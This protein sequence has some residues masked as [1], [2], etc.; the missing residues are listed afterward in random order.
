MGKLEEICVRKLANIVVP[1][2]RSN[3]EV[4]LMCGSEH[5]DGSLTADAVSLRPNDVQVDHDLFRWIEQHQIGGCVQQ[6]NRGDCC[7][8][9]RKLLSHLPIVTRGG[10]ESKQTCVLGSDTFEIRASFGRA[11]LYI[12][13]YNS[14]S[15]PARCASP[16]RWLR[17]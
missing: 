4:D 5:G 7:Q 10:G 12:A 15:V 1:V 14:A 16:R 8:A 17:R 13:Y 9:G 3:P 11:N 2:L 6:R